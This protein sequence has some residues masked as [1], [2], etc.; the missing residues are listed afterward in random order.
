MQHG[1]RMPRRDWGSSEEDSE[2]IPRVYDLHSQNKKDKKIKI[3]GVK[4]LAR[5]KS[6]SERSRMNETLQP[7]T[8]QNTASQFDIY[9]SRIM[10]PRTAKIQC[11]V[12]RMYSR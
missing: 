8:K 3:L 5:I 6:E 12:S 1:Y 9:P 7:L 10:T 2:D 11:T 4:Q